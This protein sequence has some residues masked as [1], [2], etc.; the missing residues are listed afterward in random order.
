MFVLLPAGR[1]LS[2]GSSHMLLDVKNSFRLLRNSLPV[3]LQRRKRPEF[4][5]SSHFKVGTLP[6]PRNRIST[7]ATFFP[8]MHCS[9]E[10]RVI[11]HSARSHQKT[12]HYVDVDPAE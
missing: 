7:A 12:I 1:D 4:M 6:E 2:A 3:H 5:S 11:I 10:R 9:K 8:S